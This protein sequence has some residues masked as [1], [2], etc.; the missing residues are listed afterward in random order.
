VS[1]GTV[2]AEPAPSP[3]AASPAPPEPA[4]PP[5]R[6]SNLSPA[7]A[8]RLDEIEQLARIS[9]RKHEV[10][11]EQADKRAKEAAKLGIDEKGFQLSAPDK[12]YVLRL[13]G[14]LQVDGRFFLDNDALAASDT[15]LVRRFRPSIEGTLFSIVD[16]RFLPELAGTVQVLDAF[17][18]VHPREWLRLRVGKYKA[19]IG[20][21]RLQSDADLPLLERAL[22]Q[23]LTS[24]RDVGVQLWGDIKGGL[25]HYVVG[26]FNGAPDGSGADADLSHAKDFQGRLF[27]HPFKPESLQD[28]GHLGIGLSAG[29]GN[30]RGRLPT[31]T[32]A[33]QTGL[34]PLRTSGQN[35]FF[36]YLAP[37][38]DTTGEMTTF[39]NE[40]TTRLNP[41]LYYYSGPFGLLGE[42][43]WLR[44]G[45]RRGNTAAKLTHQAAHGTLS[46]AISGTEGYDG[47]T[48]KHAFDPA[49]N[50]WGALQLA[51]RVGWLKVDDDTFPTF[52]NPASSARSATSYAAGVGWMLRRAVKFA[53]NV[54]QTRFKGGGGMAMAVTDRAIENVVIG[55]AQVNF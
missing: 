49:K 18:D 30:R 44:Q 42:Y 19:P 29:T 13:R 24:Q 23:N 21:E 11:E 25:V 47:T 39:T 46:Y 26:V 22:D 45:V 32:A 50:H 43:V 8:A 20:L 15:F 36:S 55:R 40:R 28:F 41:Q 37:P 51:V 27:F 35:T 52:A 38:T 54:E 17:A 14:L 33:A 34:S 53:V 1:G 12:S 3:D 48:P 31:A 10:L 6:Q 5:Q 7:D 9:D 2:R 16:Y 4:A